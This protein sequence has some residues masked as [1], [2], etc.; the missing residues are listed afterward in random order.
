[1]SHVINLIPEGHSENSPLL[2]ALHGNNS[3]AEETLPFWAQAI[4]QGWIT[5]V[6]QSPQAGDNDAFIWSNDIEHSKAYVKSQFDEIKEN[7]SFDPQQVVIAG[8]SMGGLIAAESAIEGMIPV[9]GF[10]VI[11]PAVPFWDRAEELEKLLP[12]AHTQKLRCYFI[13]GE[14]D[15]AIFADKVIELADKIKATDIPCKVEIVPDATHDY[16]PAYDTAL[17]R[18]LAFVSSTKE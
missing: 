10:V 9:H 5:V 2:I 14:K 18:G 16:T 1:M 17:Q 3:T 12:E 7:I 15:D 8:H 11:G 6:P 13:L 4:S